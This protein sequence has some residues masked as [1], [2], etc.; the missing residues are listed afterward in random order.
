MASGGVDS[1]L[2]W[3]ATQDSLARAYTIDWHSGEDFE[4]LD[5]DRRAVVELEARFG[6]PVDYLP[7]EDRRRRAAA[8][9]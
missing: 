5:D 9:R 8:E 3:W 4:G 2:I 7:G 1:G 6:T